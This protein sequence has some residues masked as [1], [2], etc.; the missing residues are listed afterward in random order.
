ML[1]N[2][3]VIE[4][5]QMLIYSQWYW[6]EK[7]NAFWN[8]KKQN[9]YLVLKDW[10]LLKMHSSLLQSHKVILQVA[11]VFGTYRVR[12]CFVFNSPIVPKLVSSVSFWTPVEKQYWFQTVLRKVIILDWSAEG[13]RL[14][15]C[16]ASV[17]LCYRHHVWDYKRA[18]VILS[19]EHP[20]CDGMSLDHP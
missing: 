2:S 12:I 8:S 4:I 17:C 16:A 7:I 3:L 18:N 19:V 1:I 13:T 20:N 14:T 11:L 9:L 15:Y 10:T 5:N 6:R